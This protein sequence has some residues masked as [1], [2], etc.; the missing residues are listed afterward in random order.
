MRE[1]KPHIPTEGADNPEQYRR[2]VDMAREVEADE[3]PGAMDRAF[4]RVIRSPPLSGREAS[5]VPD[6]TIPESNTLASGMVQL[7]VRQRNGKIAPSATWPR[8]PSHMG[9]VSV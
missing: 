7:I 9:S 3:T 4:N 1:R 8:F 2:F 5:E 6:Q